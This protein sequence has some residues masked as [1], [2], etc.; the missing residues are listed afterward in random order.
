MLS[1]PVLYL[2]NNLRNNGAFHAKGEEIKKG[3]GVKRESKRKT[4]LKNCSFCKG[5]GRDPNSGM[6][7]IKKCTV[8]GGT[9]TV[10]V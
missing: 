10:R 3:K 9:G 1:K 7:N 5:T 6:F 2:L 8:C 4:E